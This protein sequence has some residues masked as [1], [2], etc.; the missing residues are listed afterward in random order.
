VGDER[1]EAYLRRVAEAELRRAGRELRR[2]EAAPGG[3]GQ[4]VFVAVSRAQWKVVRTGRI[5]V[6][7]GA[8]D[9]DFL[10]RFA[11]EFHVAVTIRSRFLLDRDRR[12][13]VLV[14]SLAE[15]PLPAPPAAPA[16]AVMMTTPIGR[17]LRVRTGRAP[18][19]LHLLAAVRTGTE[20]ALTVV[21]RMHWPPDRSSADLE[22]SGAGPHHLPYDQLSV[23]DERG[24]RYS[25]Q[26]KS[27]SLGRGTTWRGIARLA[28]VPPA[29][30][31]RLDLIGDGTRLIGLSLTPGAETGL[32][33]TPITPAATPATKIPP[34]ERLLT[35]EAERILAT[36]EPRAP[37]ERPDPAE[38]SAVLKATGAI[39]AGS[40]LPGQLAALVRRLGGDWPAGTGPPA[41]P[42]AEIAEIPA[43]WSS[44]LA[45][46]NAPRPAEAPEAF[47]PVAHLLPDVDGARFVLVGLSLTDGESHLHV[48]GS[49]RLPEPADQYEHNWTPGFSWWLRDRAGHWHVGTSVEPWPFGDGLQS[50]QLRLTPP[51]TAV[52]GPVELVLTGPATQIRAVV[53]IR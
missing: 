4:E 1:A 10:L 12:R 53:P 30:V 48:I 27:G 17:V 26:F 44:V 51:L 33:A 39:A 18:A 35:V 47:A 6:A 20:A 24:T 14:H 8:L 2:I 41:A 16:P 37:R 3:P 42:A 21:M 49:G 38:I 11:S 29:T 15:P 32:A 50:F 5:L 45:G 7:A 13:G 28:P 25:L 52:T 19:D 43:P 46:D 36:R 9:R 31:R 23:V 22:A 34:G 40:P